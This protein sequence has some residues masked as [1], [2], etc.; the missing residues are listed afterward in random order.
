MLS[1]IKKSRLYK[2]IRKKI[3]DRIAAIDKIYFS[4]TGK[5]EPEGINAIN[6]KIID[7]DIIHVCSKKNVSVLS[8]DKAEYDLFEQSLHFDDLYEKGIWQRYERKILEYYLAYKLLNLEKYRGG[9][10]LDGA[11]S[12]SPW[13]LWCREHLGI[14][15]Y[16]VDIIRPERE[17]GCFI[18]ADITNLP[19]K[20]GSVN[21][22]SLQSS[23]ET[24][25]NDIDIRFIKECGRIL[26][27]GGTAIISPLYLNV[28]YCNCYGKSFYKNSEA[29]PEAKKYLR[30]DY[31]M[32][33]TRLYDINSLKKRILD[34]AKKCGLKYRI[35]IIKGDLD[36]IDRRYP[37]IY[38][39]YCLELKKV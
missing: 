9:I 30:L 12:A 39:R 4:L 18:H 24:F 5:K 26:Q 28:D 25:P 27:K 23:L 7:R 11:S 1:N 38:M 20:D 3:L 32:E 34:T 21:A 35:Y 16:S 8:I 13:A 10:Y 19:F 22:I 29:E 36:L 14:D 2:A 17:T 31:D 15:A 6:R 37:Y 33:F